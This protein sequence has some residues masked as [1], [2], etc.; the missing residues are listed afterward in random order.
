M[1]RQPTATRAR[2]LSPHITVYRWPITM[3]LSIVHRATGIALYA[4]ILLVAWWLVALATSPEWFD[5]ANGIMGSILGQLVLFGF[6]WSMF[7]HMVGGIR[8]M[9]W[10]TG[11]AMEKHTSIQTS[12]VSLIASLVLTALTWLALYLVV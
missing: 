12:W 11:V 4:G 10:D 8:H 1:S 2:P 6:T 9:L 7:M 3:V 5:T